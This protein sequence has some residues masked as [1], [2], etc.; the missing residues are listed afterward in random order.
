MYFAPIGEDFYS[1]KPR[2]LR[3]RYQEEKNT[4]TYGYC[5][6][7]GTELIKIDEFETKVDDPKVM[8]D[9]L[10]NLNYQP[11]AT[12]TKT[13]KSFTFKNYDLELDHIAELGSFLEVEIKEHDLSYEVA[14]ASCYDILS[15]LGI[16][17][18]EKADHTGYIDMILQKNK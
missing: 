14:K 9:I 5:H 16:T 15:E 18:K 7:K 3:L 6:V 10:K 4:V 17:R 8:E 12:V 13:R 2:Y 1:Y 11:Q